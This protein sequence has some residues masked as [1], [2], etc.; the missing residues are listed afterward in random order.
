[1]SMW[2]LEA[3]ACSTV[4]PSCVHTL[5]SAHATSRSQRTTSSY[6]GISQRIGCTPFMA[7]VEKRNGAIICFVIDICI[8]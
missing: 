5:A 6:L 7:S 1:M 3:A 2:P 4:L 8:S